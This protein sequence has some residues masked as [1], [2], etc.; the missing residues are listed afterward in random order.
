MKKLTLLY[1]GFMCLAVIII[2]VGYFLITKN[3]F[4]PLNPLDSNAQIIQ[5]IAIFA[6]LIGVPF[7]LWYPKYMCKKK[8]S[9]LE[10]K[11]KQKEEYLKLAEMR[12]LVVGLCLVL[13]AFAYIVLGCYKSM[14]WL[15]AICAIA[16][17][18]TK[19]TERKMEL[20]LSPEDY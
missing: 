7:A 4:E 10:D 18:F 1:Y 5:Y 14:I 11:E 3:M 12:I 13:S 8:L 2:G 17:Y 19:P 20:E 9:A 15:T 6:V 16:W